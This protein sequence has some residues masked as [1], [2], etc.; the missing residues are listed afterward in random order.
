[1]RKY[2][3]YLCVQKLKLL[4]GNSWSVLKLLKTVFTIG[5]PKY[6]SFWIDTGYVKNLEEL[7]A[8]PSVR[9]KIE[10]IISCGELP[11]Q[12]WK[13][14]SKSAQEA[15][16]QIFEKRYHTKFDEPDYGHISKK[17]YAGLAFNT[18]EK[19]VSITYQVGNESQSRICRFLEWGCPNNLAVTATC[20]DETVRCHGVTLRCFQ[21]SSRKRYD[22]AKSAVRTNERTTTVRKAMDDHGAGLFT[23]DFTDREINGCC[24]GKVSDLIG[25]THK[26]RRLGKGREEDNV[27]ASHGN[28]RETELTLPYG[29]RSC[30]EEERN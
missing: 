5:T 4:V 28:E 20:S 21:N 26:G 17:M 3:S 1:M 23:L 12:T 22:S 19:R 14:D 24:C 9:E 10:E 27:P 8:E 13:V 16:K 2:S 15:L 11:V 29:Y 6:S 25:W 30:E 18:K 7:F